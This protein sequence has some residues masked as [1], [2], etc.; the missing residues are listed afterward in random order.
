MHGGAGFPFM[1]QTALVLSK[2]I[3]NAK[4]RKIEGQT[5]AVSSEAI[6]PVLEE[7]LKS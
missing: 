3:A 2:A 1:K 6:A 7:F 4:F 5:H